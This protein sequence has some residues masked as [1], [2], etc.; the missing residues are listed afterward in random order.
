MRVSEALDWVLRV[1]GGATALAAGVLGTL[2]LIG[3]KWFDK[4]MDRQLESHKASL[5]RLT[6][7]LKDELATSKMHEVYGHL[8]E[9]IVRAHGAVGGLVGSGFA[10]SYDNYDAEDF[11]KLL[12]DAAIPH[13]E[14]VRLQEAIERDRRTGQQELERVFRQVAIHNARRKVYR[15]TNYAAL[16][17]PFL[18]PAVREKTKAFA[19]AIWNGW[20]VVHVN[21]LPGNP[22]PENPTPAL[23]EADAKLTELEEQISSELHPGGRHVGIAS[24]VTA[25]G[26]ALPEVPKLLRG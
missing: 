26:S 11:A 8:W 18:S 20:V 21:S 25:L 5:G 17:S 10:P 14:R 22:K 6:E 15:A 1:L 12:A 3:V 7:H 23:T 2:Q 16:K 4:L 13:G 9:R 24:S 19:S